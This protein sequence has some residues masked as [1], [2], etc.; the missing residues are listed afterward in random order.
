M[1]EKLPNKSWH[2]FI[3]NYVSLL[4][5]LL[6][7]ILE[8]RLETQGPG[9]C[10]RAIL[11]TLDYQKVKYPSSLTTDFSHVPPKCRSVLALLQVVVLQEAAVNK[12]CLWWPVRLPWWHWCNNLSV[13][14]KCRLGDIK[15]QHPFPWLQ[16][17]V[18]AA[19]DKNSA[20][21]LVT[22]KIMVIFTISFAVK[23]V[24]YSAFT[25]Q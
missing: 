6:I 9:N 16:L 11:W 2:W 24:G 20:F 10:L 7:K 15:G 5:F 3:N 22:V 19:W 14:A 18:Q 13:L 4:P 12:H 1:L 25:V 17:P 8:D 23:H 21:L